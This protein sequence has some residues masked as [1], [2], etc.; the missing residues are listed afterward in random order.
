MSAQQLQDVY[1]NLVTE[2]QD[3]Y[4]RVNYLE[5]LP[6]IIRSLQVLKHDIND[7]KAARATLDTDGES[8]A[9]K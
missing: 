2:G 3:G 6:V 4:L 8:I 1:P 5:M 7:V 9:E